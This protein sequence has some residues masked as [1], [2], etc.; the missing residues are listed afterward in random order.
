MR[1][2]AAED[3]GDLDELDWDPMK[4]NLV[5]CIFLS[6]AVLRASHLAESILAVV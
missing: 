6:Y 4:H 5:S 1:T 2:G 3:A